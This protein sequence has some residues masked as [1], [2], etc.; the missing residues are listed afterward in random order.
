MIKPVKRKPKPKF[1]G[2]ILIGNGPSI[3]DYNFGKEIDKF[4]EIIRF[5]KYVISNFEKHIGTRTDIWVR[6]AV[7][8]LKRDNKSFKKIFI[9]AERANKR[10]I[11]SDNCALLINS[12]IL[13][14][15]KKYEIKKRLST[16]LNFILWMTKKQNKKIIIHGFDFFGENT[17]SSK[18][19]FSEQ[20]RICKVKEHSGITEKKIIEDLIKEKKVMWLSQFLDDIRKEEIRRKKQKVKEGRCINR[21]S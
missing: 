11:T 19:Y 15:V 13:D 17:P 5:N 8:N 9:F 3:L 20:S 21:P 4:K 1:S 7:L 2:I 16:G 18:H 10:F 12:S 6:N 14:E